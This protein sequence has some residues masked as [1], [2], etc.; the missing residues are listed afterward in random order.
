[1]TNNLFSP[2]LISAS[3][4]LIGLRSSI[5]RDIV[6]DGFLDK[7]LP[8][9]LETEQAA[10]DDKMGY[11][12]NNPIEQKKP[13]PLELVSPTNL[14]GHKFFKSAAFLSSSKSLREIHRLCIGR[15]PIIMISSLERSGSEVSLTGLCL[16]GSFY[17]PRLLGS[18]KRNL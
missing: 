14:L 12:H 9:N 11:Q 1:M 17:F 2:K 7:E 3:L 8:Q 6:I 15:A 16:A 18:E 4:W 5:F 10:R 13:K